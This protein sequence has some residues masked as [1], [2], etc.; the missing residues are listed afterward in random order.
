MGS[1]P[2]AENRPRISLHATASN[3]VH[4]VAVTSGEML[5]QNNGLLNRCSMRDKPSLSS[6]GRV[7]RREIGIGASAVFPTQKCGGVVHCRRRV[8]CVLPVRVQHTQQVYP[9][10]LLR[11]I[12]LSVR[13]DSV[14]AL[15]VSD[16]C[17]QAC[18]VL[19]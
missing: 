13:C 18:G 12:R 15:T 1:F 5:F 9:V 11:T 17:F 6:G 4:T 2:L 7:S 19:S 16:V 8:V 14:V 3:G 10:G